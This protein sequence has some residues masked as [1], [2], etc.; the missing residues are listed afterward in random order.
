MP[1]LV[2]VGGGDTT[3][4]LWQEFNSWNFSGIRR[5]LVQH[6]KTNACESDQFGDEHRSK[7]RSDLIEKCG[8]GFRRLLRKKKIPATSFPRGHLSGSQVAQVLA[9][10]YDVHRQNRASSGFEIDWQF[11]GPLVGDSINWFLVIH[12]CCSHISAFHFSVV[13]VVHIYDGRRDGFRTSS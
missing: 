4:Y 9:S 12:C 13:V 8:G 3:P 2:L 1:K 11:H 7:N 10:C 6:P 5:F